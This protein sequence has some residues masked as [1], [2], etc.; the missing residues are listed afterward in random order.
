M[1]SSILL[2][3]TGGTIGMMEDPGTG[4]LAPFDFE[5]ILAQMP[6]LKRFGV[7]IKAASLK[8]PIDSSDVSIATWQEIADII[9]DHYDQCDGFVIL[10]GTDTMAYS[11]SAL[12]FML[13]NLG[14]P[15]IFTGSQ[16][17]IGRLRTDGKEN[18]I[19][20][21]ELASARRDGRPVI[22]EVAV[23]F[24]SRL[25]R[26][27]RTHKFNTE[28]F[29]A[30]ESANFSPLANIGIHII[31]QHHLLLQPSEEPF[32]VLKKMDD[33]VGILKIFP[34]ISRSVV[35]TLLNAGDLKGI[36][37]ESFGSGN[38]ST[39]QWF[40]DALSKAISG[41]KIIVN[42]TQ[43]NRGFV[44]QGRYKTSALLAQI[45]VIGGADMTTEGALTKLM[46]LLAYESDL[47]QLHRRMMT[48]L[49][50]ELTV[51]SQWM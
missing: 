9:E 12:S 10:H 2:I 15:V 13:E 19:T 37:L 3:Y 43:C 48:P 35:E 41:G 8:R 34:G 51:S 11:A 28:D 36:I 42:V 17:P 23:Y 45:G 29:D 30:F 26:G 6:E 24:E 47:V 50:G 18:L 21:I 1:K 40:I 20:A 31:Y 14:K 38:A 33:R 49:R 44:E 46:F 25:F 5:H 27:N 39:K 32:R 4:A 7:T 22:K 16:L